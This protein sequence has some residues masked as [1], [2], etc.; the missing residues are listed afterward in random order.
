[1][2]REHRK[3]EELLDHVETSASNSAQP[4]DPADVCHE[5]RC[6]HIRGYPLPP[7][8]SGKSYSFMAPEERIYNDYIAKATTDEFISALG[9]AKS[10]K[11]FLIKKD[12]ALLISHY[13]A[14]MAPRAEEKYS[15]NWDPYGEWREKEIFLPDAMQHVIANLQKSLP[16]DEFIGVMKEV[17]EYVHHRIDNRLMSLNLEPRFGTPK[18][19]VEV[20][21]KRAFQPQGSQRQIGGR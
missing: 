2:E 12:I 1:M 20:A 10:A 8:A 17:A 13:H 3:S 9:R 14:Y 11:D 7:D 19:D 4:L 15:P 18:V 5:L 6:K 21:I 16:E